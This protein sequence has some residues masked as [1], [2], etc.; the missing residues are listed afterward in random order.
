MPGVGK[1]FLKYGCFGCAGVVV[2][3]VLLLV[4]L[5]ATAFFQTQSATVEERRLEQDLPRAEPSAD[6]AIP[7]AEGRVVLDLAEA[8]FEIEPA[9]PGEPLRVEASFDSNSFELV[10]SREDDGEG[11]WIYRLSF[12]STRTFNLGTLRS[13]FGGNPPRVHVFLPLDVPMAL[14]GR[15]QKGPTTMELGKLWL[16]E[17][18]LD[19]SRGALLLGVS[20]PLAAPARSVVINGKMGA[21]VARTLGNTSAQRME[22][23]GGMGAVVADLRGHWLNDSEIEVTV[24]MGGGEVRLPQDVTIRGLSDQFARYNTGPEP[25][26]ELPRPTLDVYVH[27][28]MGNLDVVP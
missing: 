25:D 18:D 8:E 4:V 2:L 26:A 9:D 16:T 17:I 21:L 22:I 19:F 13:W 15:L 28:D 14:E 12:R 23:H 7:V 10:E 20:D 5:G 11:G 24:A 6:F 3:C 1:S 27:F